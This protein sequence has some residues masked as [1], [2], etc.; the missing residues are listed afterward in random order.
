[1]VQTPPVI[2]LGY[3][4]RALAQSA[5]RSGFAPFAMDVFADRD[6]EASCPAVRIERYPHGF[7]KALAASPGAPWM[8]TGGLENF[9]A[10][11]EHLALMRPLWGNGAAVVQSVRR[12]EN[13]AKVV[14]NAG[15][16]FPEIGLRRQ[17]AVVK[18]HRG[19]GGIDV[20]PASDQD[21]AKVPRGCY[22]QELIAGRTA[23]AVFVAARGD[24]VLLKATRQLV[25][26]DFGL[27]R[28][29]IYVGSMGPLELGAKF[30]AKLDGLG[31]S[32]AHEF[33]LVGLFNVDFVIV[34]DEIWVLEVNP[35]YSASVEVLELA[36]GVAYVA[37]H[38]EAC[39]RGAL[40]RQ[41]RAET[42]RFSGKA[43][44][45][46][47]ENGV[48]PAAI[49]ALAAQWQREDGR[50]G[51]ADIPQVGAKLSS[52]EPV[53]TVLASGGSMEDVERTLRLRCGRLR[54]L[55]VGTSQPL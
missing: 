10:L 37:L 30:T 52:G 49:D 40:P 54:E 7:L 35:R 3:S 8:Y 12:V 9:P 6:L 22:L 5:L 17:P 33:S 41:A 16:R 15:C 19:S 50:P 26:S 48:V 43:V 29:F 20:R 38:A 39:T 45:Y 55:L 31:Q 44:Y 28:P 4:V 23:S 36:G 21:F 46:A 51:L 14:V 42:E 11:L 18:P 53:A 25:G 1:M 27:A 13:L 34:D 24:A 2:V 32:L 47:D